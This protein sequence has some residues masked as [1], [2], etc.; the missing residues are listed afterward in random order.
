MGVNATNID[1]TVNPVSLQVVKELY[2]NEALTEIKSNALYAAKMI[3]I[4]SLTMSVAGGVY[5]PTLAAHGYPAGH[6]GEAYQYTSEAS[7]IAVYSVKATLTKD[8]SAFV[9]SLGDTL[10]GRS[11][12][13]IYVTDGSLYNGSWGHVEGTRKSVQIGISELGLN[14]YCMMG[15][16]TRRLDGNDM[17]SI[18]AAAN[19]S[20][21]FT[22]GVRERTLTLVLYKDTFYIY[23]DGN[24]AKS[25][26]ITSTSY[27]AQSG[28]ALFTAGSALRFGVGTS[29]VNA[30]VNP[31]S[32]TV[33]NDL[34]GSEALQYIKDNY[35]ANITVAE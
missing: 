8:L 11:L 3:A 10:N 30:N 26:A 12:I 13:G 27:F 1:H 20:Y 34:S 9:T 15:E 35:S 23:V 33:V 7:T 2:G 17:Y 4:E 28:A 25:V 18:T 21:G 14:S 32:F 19:T 22:A 24:F 29:Y 16:M 31:V 6:G 5:T